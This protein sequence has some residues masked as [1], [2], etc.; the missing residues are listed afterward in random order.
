MTYRP[1]SPFQLYHS[2]LDIALRAGAASPMDTVELLLEM[3]AFAKLG[4]DD[5]L[6]AFDDELT[7]EGW[8][9]ARDTLTHQ[10]SLPD[11]PGAAE[12]FAGRSPGLLEETRRAVA[13]VAPIMA[14]QSGREFMAAL[15]TF[16]A[17]A[18]QLGFRRTDIGHSAWPDYLDLLF[19]S[20]L[21][22][23]RNQS[24]YVPFDSSG[25]L[26]LLLASGGTKVACELRSQQTARVFSLFA[27]LAGWPVEVRVADPMRAP[28]FAEGEWL[29]RFDS[30]AAVLTFGMRAKDEAAPDLY[31]RFPV[32]LLYGEGRQI[33]H[34]IAQTE[35]TVLAVAPEGFLFRPTGG[36]RDYK[37]HLVRR[38]ILSAVIRLPRSAFSP[39]ANIQTSLLV[40]NAGGQ[41]GG[42][43]LFVDATDDLAR[44][45]RER[46]EGIFATVQQIAALVRTRREGP[47]SVLAS[48]DAIS[49]NDF[50]LSVDRYVRSNDE[51]Q[52]AAL[53]AKAETA[54]L[55]DVAEIIRPQSFPSDGTPPLHN[56]AEVALQD[57]TPDGGIAL[58]AKRVEIDDRALAKVLRQ[59]LEPGDVL[60]S[61]RGRI[62]ATAIVPEIVL[63]HEL[64]GWLASQAFVV[65]R[66]RKT[67]PLTP[68]ALFRYLASPLAQ[69]LLRPLATGSTVPMIAMGDLKKL[70]VMVP[71]AQTEEKIADDQRRLAALRAQIT[72]LEREIETLSAGAWPMDGVQPARRRPKS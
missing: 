69:T 1:P 50:N 54:L 19:K 16:L 17:H 24:V 26:A 30:A 29:T 36:E 68:L 23:P 5:R 45:A 35:G 32:R 21:D 40:L 60:L 38:G 3:L 6:P 18:P 25:W 28:A 44:K 51:Q 62:G 33:A 39:Q 34:M 64:S 37:E 2:V 7:R 56:F 59:R 63:D 55:G 15:L 58:P 13:S 4:P 71:S 70:P 65:L 41:S 22:Q 43:V 27:Y 47:V 72:H 42:K 12:G 31:D 53:L 46:G 67:R 66:L 8:S 48:Y 49:S 9:R 14:G 57:L 11:T 20:L 52:V 61:V 10:L